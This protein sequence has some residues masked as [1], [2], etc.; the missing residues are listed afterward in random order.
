MPPV[1]TDYTVHCQMSEKL[2]TAC[3]LLILT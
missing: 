3:A 2:F 1:I